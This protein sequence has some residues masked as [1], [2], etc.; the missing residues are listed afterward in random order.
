MAKG[1]LWISLPGKKDFKAYGLSPATNADKG[2][3]RWVSF[4]VSKSY[5]WQ[6]EENEEVDL[7]IS[8]IPL[9]DSD[10]KGKSRAE[11]LE[12]LNKAIHTIQSQ[13]LGKIVVSRC[14]VKPARPKPLELFKALVKEYP[15]ACVYLFYHPEIGCWLGASPETLLQ[16]EGN[17]LETMSLAGT[18]K[19]DDVSDF[20]TKEKVEQQL[21]TDYI[22]DVL[23]TTSGVTNIKAGKVS[24]KEAGNLLHLHS[25]IT[26]EVRQGF[27]QQSLLTKLHPTP[28]VAGNPLKPALDFIKNEE[29]YDRSFYTGYF[30]IQTAS[31]ATY[32]VNLRC[33]QVFSNG[34]I[35]YAG[36]GIT[37]NSDPE[38]EWEETVAKMQTLSSIF[39]F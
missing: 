15:P 32:W 4:D 39:A 9:L 28:A 18:R 7:D 23:S 3:F 19:R 25:K 11:Y 35:L 6:L 12:L 1:K 36:G 2:L 20:T 30:G 38:S 34:K 22:I 21:V 17:K 26:A 27:D 31:T 14:E 13:R 10:D 33:M 16:L 24:E 5:S 29:A 8:E 37:A